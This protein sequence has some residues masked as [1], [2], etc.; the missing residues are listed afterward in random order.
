MAENNPLRN[1]RVMIKGGGEMAS[2]VA[3]RLFC[4]HLKVLM[5]EIPQPLCIRREV[6]FCEAI[7]QG[8]KEV[9]GVRAKYISSPQEVYPTWEEGKIPLL[10]DPEGTSRNS[11]QPH[12]IVDAILAKRNT[13]TYKGDA[14]L[15]I[16]LGPGFWAGKDVDV[17]VETN[18]GHYL[19][20]VIP[21]GP[22]QPDTGVP[23]EI[24]GVSAQRVLRAPRD[25]IFHPVKRIGDTVERGEVVA[26]VEEEP[27]KTA[28]EGVIRG[29]LREG[30][31]VQ[32]G[33]KAGDVDPRGMKDHCYS[34][35]D[36]A[37]AIGGSVLE[38]I[39]AH[40]NR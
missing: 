32:G 6:S 36:K 27:I 12:V 1:I 5:T 13:G 40:F 17:V 28:I 15:V 22:A 33:L 39:L 37:R 7:F 34:I 30:T 11:I 21:E 35:S 25:G 18:R 19:G 29:L 23:G 2:G 9:E 31:K 24:T 38:A 10:I 26:W 8:E 20:R 16:G 3:H 4:S 14:P